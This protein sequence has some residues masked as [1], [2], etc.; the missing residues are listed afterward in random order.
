MDKIL[1]ISEADNVAVALRVIEKGARATCG[2]VE[3]RALNEIPFGHKIALCNIPAGGDV[4]KYGHL[5]GHASAD[6]ARGELVDSRNLKTSLGEIVNYVYAPVKAPAFPRR[7][8]FFNGYLRPNSE[9]GIRNELWIV[10]LV[11]CVNCVAQELE[12]RFK[13]N[14]LAEHIDGVFALTHSY[15]CSQLGCDH[16]NT[17][18]ILAALCANPNAGGVLVLGLGCENNKMD[19]FKAELSKYFPVR[20][21]F[22]TAQTEEDE[23]GKGMELLGELSA[24]MKNDTRTKI[25]FSKLKI[26]LKCGGSD[27]FSGITANVLIGRFAD[28]AVASGASC[29]LC[30][31]PE[32]FGAET[33]L[34][35]RARDRATFEKIVAM[36]NNFKRYFI[37]NSMPVYENPSPGNKAGGITTLEEKSLGCVQKGGTTT[38]N[39]VLEYAERVGVAGLSLLS[40]PGNDPVAATALAAAGCQMVLFSTGRGTPFA[41]VV[42]TVKISSNTPLFEKKKRW[43]DFDAGVLLNG[44][45]VSDTEREFFDFVRAV[46]DGRPTRAELN[47]YREIAIF[48]TGI[49]L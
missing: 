33:L 14:P 40:T 48:K 21:R 38:V 32:M 3:V 1:R 9:A 8:A 10:P 43:M 39:G 47:G 4:V 49:T 16:A 2:G 22:L 15:G 37:S 6:I 12:R 27:A 13:T 31:V 41:T 11:S 25:P 30:E 26:G 46:A 18:K 5:I 28:A 36:I 44:H 29:V 23:I 45:S 42:P 7:E 34:M 24:E 17:R 35:N 19:A 20:V